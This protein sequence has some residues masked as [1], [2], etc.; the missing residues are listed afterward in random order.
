MGGHA[1]EARL[2]AEDPR[3]DFLPATGRVHAFELP[4][5]PGLRVDS[6]VEAGSSVSI[7]YD[8]ML[9]KVIAHAPTRGLAIDTLARALREARIHGPTTNRELLVRTLEHEEF[10]AGRTDTHFLDRHDPAD[11]ARPL[12]DAEGEHLSAVAAALADQADERLRTR[13]LTSIPSGWR[14]RPGV[15]QER[16]YRGDQGDHLIR[17]SLS[18]TATVEGPGPL[19]LLACTPDAVDISRDGVE[20]SFEV[21][22]YGEVRHVDSALGPVRLVVIPRFPDTNVTETPGSLHA[23]MPGRVTRVEVE[24]GD[25]VGAGQVLLVMEAMKMEHTLRAPHAGV[26]A[27]VDCGPGD[28]VEAG[29]VLVVVEEDVSTQG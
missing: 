28:Q 29:A 13:V 3:N 19:D 21:A 8:P 20:T 23:P 16:G 12:V 7:F 2:Y 24:R 17:Y 25:R 15:F 18:G 4:G 27:E 26:I 10:R 6:G 14:N 11:L 22:R 5:L 9:A 1:I